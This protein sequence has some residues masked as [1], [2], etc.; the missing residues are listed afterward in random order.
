MT[1]PR[2]SPSEP[3]TRPRPSRRAWALGPLLLLGVS[4]ASYTQ[5]ADAALGAFRSGDFAR[6]RELFGGGS[7]T[8]SDFLRGAEAGS[9]SLAAGDWEAALADFGQ[10]AKAVEEIERES[11]TSPEQAGRSILSWTV[12]ESFTDYRGEGY[13]RVL[14]HVGLGLAYLARGEVEDMLVEVRRANA[15]LEGEEKL[16]D[17]EYAAGGMGHLLSALGYELLG[18][19][20]D[21][22]ID[23]RRMSEKGLAQDLVGPALVR[24]S[25]EL[26]RTDTGLWIDQYG[27][28]DYLPEGAASV[29]L[30]A[31]VALGPY[32]QATTLTIPTK[33]A[34]AQWSVPTYVRRADTP[35]ALLL[36]S[37]D[38]PGAARAVVVEDVASVAEKNLSD[39]LAW[40]ATK[41]AVRGLMKRQLTRELS[42][43]Y[44]PVARVA[45]DL[46]TLATERADLRSWLT[47][48]ASYQ[49]ARLWLEPGA[50]ELTLEVQGGDALTLGNFELAPGEIV[51]VLARSLGP[52]VYAHVIGGD[53]VVQSPAQQAEPTPVP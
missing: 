13:E 23:Y 42:E 4:C 14:V 12:N 30:I 5:R 53:P 47:L 38:A 1:R 52:R 48:P 34:L 37:R 40:L 17:T 46:F 27:P 21:A 49:A 41:S 28:A 32:K 2:T 16:Y 3:R 11:L 26:G 19:L 8:D 39:R 50:H 33:G 35:G 10:A 44:G 29:V 6:S 36:S 9:A 51:F 24:L 15:L 20:D 45:G 18:R 31:G 43:E 22:F 7:V 25:E